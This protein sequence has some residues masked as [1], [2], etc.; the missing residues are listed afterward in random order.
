MTRISTGAFLLMAMV[1][2]LAAGPA[3][4]YRWRDD[5]LFTSMDVEVSGTVEFNA[6]DSDVQSISGDGHFRMEHWYA[7]K[8]RT[9]VV[10]PGSNGPERIY[11]IDGVQKAFDA[12]AK[13]WLARV[14]P[15]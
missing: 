5:G 9:Y 12:D 3:Q 15:E 1:A 7:G 10:R 4:H 6:N 8:T 2:C 11:T 14:L 13:A